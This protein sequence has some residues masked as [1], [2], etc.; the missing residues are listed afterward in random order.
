M[1]KLLQIGDVVLIKKGVTIMADIPKKFVY[2]NTPFDNEIRKSIIEVGKIYENIKPNIMHERDSIIKDIIDVFEKRGLEVDSKNIAKLIVDDIKYPDD[3]IYVFKGG[4][5]E[6]INTVLVP[7]CRNWNDWYPEEYR[8][9]CK[10]LK[11]GLHDEDGDEIEFSQTGAV[12][13]L[14]D[15][16]HPIDKMGGEINLKNIK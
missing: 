5:F 12:S 13:T 14:I 7:E 4:E 8:V 1:S 15:N 3:A 11:N 10:R 16:I 9:I 2:S 6:V